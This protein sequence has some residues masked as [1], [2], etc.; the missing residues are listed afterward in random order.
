MNSYAI[1]Q[2]INDFVSFFFKL[3]NGLISNS[4]NNN[5]TEAI[6]CVVIEFRGT[7]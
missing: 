4:P 5:G 7:N 2:F 6:S 3:C 1:M